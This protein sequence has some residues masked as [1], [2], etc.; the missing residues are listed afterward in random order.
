VKRSPN[1]VS[2]SSAHWPNI[3]GGAATTT[4][5][6]RRRNSISRRIRPASD[7]LAETNVIGDQQIDARQQERFAQRFELLGVAAN[8]GSEGRLKKA[9]VRRGD[10]AP[11]HRSGRGLLR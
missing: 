8:A 6:I 2:S 5:S 11:A 1:R 7:G 10:A 3:A 4:K 9:R